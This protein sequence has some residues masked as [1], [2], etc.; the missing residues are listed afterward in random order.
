[1]GRWGLLWTQENCRWQVPRASFK[2]A[3]PVTVYVWRLKKTTLS[4][5]GKADQLPPFLLAFSYPRMCLTHAPK[6]GPWLCVALALFLLFDYGR[7]AAFHPMISLQK[8][9]SSLALGLPAISWV[10]KESWLVF[11]V[12][13]MNFV[14]QPFY[15]I[16]VFSFPW[17]SDMNLWEKFWGQKTILSHITHCT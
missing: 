8:G 17:D 16:F 5:P 13:P 11:L 1:M 15:F 10:A 14:K 2:A 6:Y 12:L 4:L 3:S 7:N 9:I